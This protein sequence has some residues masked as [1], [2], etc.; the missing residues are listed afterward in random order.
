[1]WQFLIDVYMPIVILILIVVLISYLGERL[2]RKKLNPNEEYLNEIQEIHNNGKLK[3]L[4]QVNWAIIFI[5]AITPSFQGS[6]IFWLAVSIIVELIRMKYKLEYLRTKSDNE[7][8][9][10]YLLCQL[11]LIFILFIVML[12]YYIIYDKLF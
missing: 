4:T 10:K 7:D 12:S 9:R 6:L 3:I 8:T 2:L 1:M 11:G 5:I